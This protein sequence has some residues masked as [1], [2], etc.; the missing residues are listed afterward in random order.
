MFTVLF[1]STESAGKKGP[2]HMTHDEHPRVETTLEGLAKLPPVFQKDNG[3]VT[4]GSASGM[5]CC[6]SAARRAGA[7]LLESSDLLHRFSPFKTN[8]VEYVALYATA[9]ICDGAASLILASEEAVK[10]HNLKPL[11]RLAGWATYVI[12]LPQ[13]PSLSRFRALLLV[14]A[15]KIHSFGIALPC[16]NALGAA[17]HAEPV[18]TLASWALDPC[19]PSARC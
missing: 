10:T 8:I 2:E 3:R 12:R 19:R 14:C 16:S 5:S 18:W 4:A 11:A 7:G 1:C 17:V 15:H 6:E 13:I 9:G